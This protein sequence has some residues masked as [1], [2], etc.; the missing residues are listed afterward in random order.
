MTDDSSHPHE[1]FCHALVRRR[2]LV[3]LRG[4]FTEQVRSTRVHAGREV[5]GADGPQRRQQLIE[6][7]ISQVVRSRR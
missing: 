6:P 7:R 4:D 1:L 3:E 2:Q 5:A